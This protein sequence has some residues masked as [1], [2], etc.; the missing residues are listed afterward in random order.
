LINNNP[1]NNFWGL[2]EDYNRYKQQDETK[3]FH[4]PFPFDGNE[5]G[6][7]LGAGDAGGVL[8]GFGS[9]T[10]FETL[11]VLGSGV[12]KLIVG[13]TGS[14]LGLVTGSYSTGLVV[15]SIGLV[16]IGCA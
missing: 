6:G 2:P 3:F 7:F 11:G 5:A 9:L 16:G 14:E 8:T 1:N 10:G 12:L 13:L 4:F 15:D